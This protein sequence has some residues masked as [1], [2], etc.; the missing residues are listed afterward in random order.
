MHTATIKSVFTATILAVSLLGTGVVLADGGRYHN[1][2]QGH[3]H[4][5][6]YGHVKHFR[7]HH[8][9]RSRYGGHHDRVYY[10]KGYPGRQ[11]TNYYEYDDDNDDEKLLIGLALGGLIG[12]AINHAGY[13]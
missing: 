13:E 2:R 4:Q 5:R 9:K 10:Y 11:V 7:Q 6:D 3:G 1:D 8:K 12:Y